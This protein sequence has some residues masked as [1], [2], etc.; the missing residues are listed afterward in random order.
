MHYCGGQLLTTAIVQK[1]GL[2]LKTAALLSIAE[3]NLHYQLYCLRNSQQAGR[4]VATDQLELS[5]QVM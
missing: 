3:L 5:V 4:Q 2:M 1:G